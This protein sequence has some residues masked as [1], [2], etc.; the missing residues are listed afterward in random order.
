MMAVLR[1]LIAT[2]VHLAPSR[3][4]TTDR[5]GSQPHGHALS[6][7]RAGGKLPENVV[8]SQFEQL[9]RRVPCRNRALSTPH[10]ECHSQCLKQQP[11]RRGPLQTRSRCVLLTDV[12]G[13]NAR[14][15]HQMY[16]RRLPGLM[17]VLSLFHLPVP[18]QITSETS[19]FTQQPAAIPASI[20]ACAPHA[21]S[22][23]ATRNAK[24]SS[25]SAAV[26]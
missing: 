5:A 4:A 22:K 17:S 18:V 21:K 1:R 10:H 16:F 25:E 8:P 2:D 7:T 12:Y 13:V 15:T 6:L 24:V 26:Q 14:R 11:S 3:S 9:P 19:S 20:S 23:H